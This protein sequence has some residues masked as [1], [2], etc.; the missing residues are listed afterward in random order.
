GTLAVDLG[1]AVLITSL[2]R[3]RLGQRAWRA[4]HWLAYLAW[5]AA[6]LHSL[7]AGNDLGVWW[8]ALVEVGSAAAGAAARLAPGFR[9]VRR[10]PGRIAVRAAVGRRPVCARPVSGGGPMNAVDSGRPEVGNAGGLRAGHLPRL[11]PARI[12]GGPAS[13]AEHLARHGRPPAIGRDA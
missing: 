5:P 4:V 10:G 7:T 3:Q 2:V 6:F 9:P 11:L 12:W 8:V 1:G 13:L